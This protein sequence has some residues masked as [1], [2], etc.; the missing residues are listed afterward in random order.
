MFV[1]VWTR[2]SMIGEEV[3]YQWLK[4]CGQ[5]GGKIE[6]KV[7][8]LWQELHGNLRGKLEIKEWN[9]CG[10]LCGQGCKRLHFKS[11]RPMAAAVWTERKMMIGED[12]RNQ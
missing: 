10:E 1:M 8:A 11:H 6:Q 5:G 4:L 12:V 7:R 9:L 2:T 3:R